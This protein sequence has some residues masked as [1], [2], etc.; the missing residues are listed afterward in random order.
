MSNV[1]VVHITIN[2][3][4]PRRRFDVHARWAWSFG[5]SRCF[6]SQ[7]RALG[8]VGWSR[9][10]SMSRV[11]V[12]VTCCLKVTCLPS[13]SR[14]RAAADSPLPE[15]VTIKPEPMDDDD[16]YDA[17]TSSSSSAVGSA[18][19]GGVTTVTAF[20]N[21]ASSGEQRAFCRA[22]PRETGSRACEW[23]PCENDGVAHGEN[24]GP[25]E[26]ENSCESRFCIPV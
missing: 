17:K 5:L 25:G 6:G 11:C 18:R 21:I 10:V 22:C 16:A 8:H 14:K 3:V 20:P 24:L 9:V 23:R 7:C 13:G 2:T 1:Y 19:S 15:P 12:E 26:N 4:G